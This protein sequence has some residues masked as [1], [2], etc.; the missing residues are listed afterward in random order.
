MPDGVAAGTDGGTQTSDQIPR[1]A[2]KGIAH[3]FHR[4]PGNTLGYTTPASMDQAQ[5][6][7]NRIVEQDRLTISKTE[8]EGSTR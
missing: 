6:V 3:G 1:A 7:M 2:A 8:Q 5:G 4:P